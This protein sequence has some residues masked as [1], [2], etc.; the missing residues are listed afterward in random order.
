MTE[1]LF[2]YTEDLTLR[3]YHGGLNTEDLT[4]RIYH[5]RLNTEDL[6]RRI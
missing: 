5:G 2:Y 3:I 4:R 6:T 1:W